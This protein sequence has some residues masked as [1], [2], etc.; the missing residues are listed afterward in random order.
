MLLG[1]K[2]RNFRATMKMLAR[3]LKPYRLHLGLALFCSV[4]STVFVIIGP[5]LMGDATT[6][7]FEGV[8]SKVMQ[9]PGAAIDFDYI[10]RILLILLVLYLASTVFSYIMGYIITGVSMKVTYDLRKRI[11]EKIHRLPLKYFDRVPHGEVLSRVT[12]DVDTVS[13]TL[14]QSMSQIVTAVVTVLGVLVMMFS[15]SWLMTVVAL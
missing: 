13:Q 3:Y 1:E 2:P 9:V 12:N 6:R 15:I 14:T 10:G 4:A 7:L 11:A 8:V 5:R